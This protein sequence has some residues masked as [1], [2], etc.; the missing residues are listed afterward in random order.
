MVKVSVA[1]QGRQA[2]MAP[3]TGNGMRYFEFHINILMYFTQRKLKLEK[4]S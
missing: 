4:P 3:F 2:K 1:K